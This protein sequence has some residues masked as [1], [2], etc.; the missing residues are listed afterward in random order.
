MRI[1][2]VMNS[3]MRKQS[4]FVVCSLVMGIFTILSNVGLLSTSAVLISRAAL[5]PDVLDLM[6]LIVG[7]RFFGISRGIFRYFERILSHDATFRILSSTREWFYKN[8]NENYSERSK[9]KTGDIYTKIVTDVDN[10]GI[11]I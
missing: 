8:F 2:K 7:V 3:L 11:S 9:F 6:V 1:L 10:L 4:F 5:R